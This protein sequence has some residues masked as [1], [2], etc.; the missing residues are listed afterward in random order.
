M[1]RE[2]ILVTLT[3]L[4]GITISLAQENE[5]IIVDQD[6]ELINLQ[7]SIFIHVTWHQLDN[8]SRFPSN[9]LIII[10]NGQALMIDTPMDNDKTERL[11]KYIKR[12][13]NADLTKLIIGHFHDDCLGGLDYL[14]NAGVESIA[15][16]RTIDKCKEIG[17]PIPS[18]PFTDSLIF[19]FN[20]V[21]IECRYF[22]AGHSFDN[23]T[24]WL[25]NNKI[26][27]G[28]CLVRSGNSNSLGN[29]SDAVVS[30]WDL[31]IKQ[32][33]Y[34]YTDI[35]I[36]IPGH[37]NYGGKEILAHTIELVEAERKK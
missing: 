32:L 37:G 28:G 24:V 20:G 22:G 12:S 1:I 33:M 16:T 36:V 21:K 5:R 23:I 11:S 31:T 9:G 30:E 6:I 2:G 18:T 4:L 34:E 3:A 10:K 13:L 14:Q 35:K 26:L 19:D 8:S 15:N 17:L 25:P 29:L 7:D 27:F